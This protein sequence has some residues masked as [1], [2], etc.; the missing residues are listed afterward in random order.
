MSS[1]SLQVHWKI[2]SDSDIAGDFIAVAGSVT[3]LDGQ[4]EAEIILSLLPD[5]VPELEELFVVSLTSVEG[6]AT[7]DGNP[8]LISTHIRCVC[9]FLS[10][11]NMI[12]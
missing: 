11:L 8:D 5:S 1:V 3:L 7:L 4:R 12:Y 10:L 9:V 2:Q 6:G